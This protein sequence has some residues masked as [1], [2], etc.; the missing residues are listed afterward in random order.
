ML[1]MEA[2]KERLRKL[3]GGRSQAQ[4]ELQT[5]VKQTT[6]SGW[7]REPPEYMANLAALAK[8]Y[9]TSADYLL[10]LT[11]DPRPDPTRVMKED[12][13]EYVVNVDVGRVVDL[14]L[15][16]GEADRTFV[17]EMLALVEQRSQPRIIGDE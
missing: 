10:G 17:M 5:G 15:S 8:Y 4:V 16:L 6:L 7:E 9:R 14:F 1:G 12:T 2:M 11:N 13:A 3:R